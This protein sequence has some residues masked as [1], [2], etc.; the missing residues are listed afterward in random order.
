MALMQFDS[1]VQGDV[2]KHFG[3]LGTCSK[4]LRIEGPVQLLLGPL[5]NSWP[6]VHVAFPDWAKSSHPYIADYYTQPGQSDKTRT[7]Q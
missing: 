5:D 6:Q 4:H 7:E 2:G 3:Q 1:I